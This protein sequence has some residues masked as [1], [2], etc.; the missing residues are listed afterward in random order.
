MVFAQQLEKHQQATLSDGSTVLERAVIEHN[1]LAASRIYKN[2]TFEELGSLLEMGDADKA[3]RV[4]SRMI[5]EGRMK[6]TIDQVDGCLEFEGGSDVMA[7]FDS[8]IQQFCQGVN[9][10]IEHITAKYPEFEG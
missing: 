3:E 6:A 1:M 4:A 7:T 9:T 5:S 2:V 10:C 8:Q